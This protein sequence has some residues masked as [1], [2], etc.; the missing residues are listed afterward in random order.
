MATQ[1]NPGAKLPTPRL[2]NLTIDPEERESVALPHLHTWA[3]VHLNKIIADFEA[4]LQREPL[5]P[6]EASLDHIPAPP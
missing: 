5:I 1:K 4:N 6:L 2:I 3:A